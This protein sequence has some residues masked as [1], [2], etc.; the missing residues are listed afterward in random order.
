VA[1]GLDF[2]GERATT[3]REPGVDERE[4]AIV[5]EI[6]VGPDRLRPPDLQQEHPVGDTFDH[7]FGTRG[8]HI[9]AGVA[10][11]PSP[12]RPSGRAD[13]V[14]SAIDEIAPR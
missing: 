11:K 14:A 2:G 6:G 12:G 5:D 7:S 8:P 3:H 9:N 10:R 13:R 4:V 1:S